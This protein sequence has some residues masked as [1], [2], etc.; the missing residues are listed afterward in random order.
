M[1]RPVTAIIVVL[2]FLPTSLQ[3]S[4][5]PSVLVVDDSMLI[6]HAVCRF[7]EDRGFRVESAAN[8]AEAVEMLTH[9][10]P[11]IIITDVQMP[12]MDGSQLIDQLKRDAHTSGIPIVVLAGR[13]N[14]PESITGIRADYLIYKDIDIAGQLQ[15]VL[16]M[17]LPRFG[18][19]QD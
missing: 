7:F 4:I 13:K 2:P 9:F 12:K 15:H 17:A 14:G 6:R 8:G 10:R 11:D 16:E 1:N 19:S 5:M 3:V 18:S